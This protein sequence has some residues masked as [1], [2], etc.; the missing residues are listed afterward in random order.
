M[1]NKFV[2]EIYTSAI[3]CRWEYS[4]C[5]T[6]VYILAQAARWYRR[7]A[8][9]SR[10]TCS[11]RQRDF[12]ATRNQIICARAHSLTRIYA[13]PIKKWIS[14]IA[15]RSFCISRSVYRYIYVC[16]VIYIRAARERIVDIYIKSRF[17]ATGQLYLIYVLLPNGIS[18]LVS[19]EKSSGAIE[20]NELF[21]ISEYIVREWNSFAG[22]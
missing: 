20:K 6:C 1:Y 10:Y 22:S 7:N 19:R 18:F 21:F 16:V 12:S 3:H 14:C 4:C 9:G 15:E 13:N 8:R 2:C 5:E 17:S 11:K